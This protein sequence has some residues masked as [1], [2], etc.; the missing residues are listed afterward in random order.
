MNKPE[1]ETDIETLIEAMVIL[2]NNIE[3]YD[4]VA[5]VAILEAAN[6]LEQ[7]RKEIITLKSTIEKMEKH[8]ER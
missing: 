5:N 8:N 3:S 6:R 1:H 7:Y 2:S 4:G